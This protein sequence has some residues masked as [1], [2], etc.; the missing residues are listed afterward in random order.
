MV[1][2]VGEAPLPLLASG[3]VEDNVIAVVARLGDERDA[4]RRILGAI[5]RC[6]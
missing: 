6:A 4:V 3:R 2:Y 5:A 1:L